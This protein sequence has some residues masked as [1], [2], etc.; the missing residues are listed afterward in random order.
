M[1][2]FYDPVSKLFCVTFDNSSVKDKFYSSIK[3]LNETI[4]SSIFENYINKKVKKLNEQVLVEPFY[5]TSRNYY[6]IGHGVKAQYNNENNKTKLKD[7][8]YMFNA[9]TNGECVRNDRVLFMKNIPQKKCSR[10][11]VRKF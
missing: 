3:S 2:S 8:F 5:N 9:N 7:D 1:Q 6:L 11:F 4:I 10:K